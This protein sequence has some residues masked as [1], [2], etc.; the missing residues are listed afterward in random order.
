MN[1]VHR[2]LLC[3]WEVASLQKDGAK[4][5]RVLASQEEKEE[6]KTEGVSLYS[7][8]LL[9]IKER[10]IRLFYLLKM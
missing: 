8:Y 5:A 6:E 7:F 4:K 1:P 9:I 3:P 10:E 2:W